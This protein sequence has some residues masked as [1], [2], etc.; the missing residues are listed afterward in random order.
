MYLSW[1]SAVVYNFQEN[2]M[3]ESQFFLWLRSKFHDLNNLLTL[4]NISVLCS[5]YLEWGIG[6][7]ERREV[8]TRLDIN[9]FTYLFSVS[10]VILHS[11]LTFDWFSFSVTYQLS[12]VMA[13]ESKHKKDFHIFDQLIFR[14]AIVT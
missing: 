7:R 12:W 1:L 6:Q 5:S 2:L 3:K 4:G 13:I 10:V 8:V 11:F 14:D 9:N